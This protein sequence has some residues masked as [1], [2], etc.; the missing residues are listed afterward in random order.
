MTKMTSQTTEQKRNEAERKERH[1]QMDNAIV[2]KLSD[3]APKQMKV[4][5]IAI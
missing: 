1:E 3:R 2:V 5:G 4:R